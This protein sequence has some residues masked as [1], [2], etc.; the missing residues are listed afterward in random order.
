MVLHLQLSK[1]PVAREIKLENQFK[2]NT[3]GKNHKKNTTPHSAIVQNC[4]HTVPI[5]QLPTNRPLRLTI[6][7]RDPVPLD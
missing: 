2:N 3:L 7:R 4:K 5:I 6:K 1:Q